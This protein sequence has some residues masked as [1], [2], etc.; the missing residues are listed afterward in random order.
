MIENTHLHGLGGIQN[1]ESIALPKYNMR[2]HIRSPFKIFSF[3][4]HIYGMCKT[5]CMVIQLPKF[6]FL[7]HFQTFIMHKNMGLP[8]LHTTWHE[9]TLKMSGCHNQ[10]LGSVLIQM[11]DLEDVPQKTL[12]IKLTS[13]DNNNTRPALHFRLIYTVC[14]NHYTCWRGMGCHLP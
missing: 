14:K 13:W 8:A 12:C 4:V 9:T 1:H 2:L 10:E 11:S 5:L 3:Q 6:N 7:T